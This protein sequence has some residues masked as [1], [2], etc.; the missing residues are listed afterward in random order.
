MVFPVWYHAGRMS[1][2]EQR[3]KVKIYGSLPGRSPLLVR[4]PSVGDRRC[5]LHTLAAVALGR[6]SAAA[7]ADIGVEIL[8]MSGWRARRWKSREQYEDHVTRKYGSVAEGRKWLAYESPHE[9]GLAIDIGSGGLWADRKTRDAQREQPLHRWLVE[10]AWE[11][12]WHPYKREP[13]HWEHPLSLDA[14]RS[15]EG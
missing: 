14:Y 5:R 3:V 9:T 4:V 12:G 15:G 7:Q 1:Y 6:M 10:H 11:H 13:W 8:V 2:E